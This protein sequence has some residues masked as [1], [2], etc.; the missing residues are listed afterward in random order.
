MAKEIDTSYENCLDILNQEVKNKKDLL[1][2]FDEEIHQPI[3]NSGNAFLDKH[4]KGMPDFDH[5]KREIFKEVRVRFRCQED[6]DAFAEL[7]GQ[8][9]T[10]KTSGIWFPKAEYEKPGLFAWIET[11]E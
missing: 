4:W 1:D 5:N 8:T 10:N 2:F 3:N 7:V 9:I 6:V 11:D